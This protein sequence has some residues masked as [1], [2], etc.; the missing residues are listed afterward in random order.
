MNQALARRPASPASPISDSLHA[1]S[2]QRLEILTFR[3]GSEDYGVPLQSVQEIRTYEAPTKLA[4]ASACVLGVLDL[5]G[6]VVPIV[7]LRQRFALPSAEFDVF[8]VTIII[9]LRERN[10]GIVVDAVHDVVSLSPAQIHAM[11]GLGNPDDQ[12]HLAAIASF[13]QR[14]IIMLNIE[15]LLGGGALGLQSTATDTSIN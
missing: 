8:T 3:L 10:V 9:N 5:R 11:P 7:D 12:R 6:E 15:A 14:S 4:G 1:E 2:T 13:E